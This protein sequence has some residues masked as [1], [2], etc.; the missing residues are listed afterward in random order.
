[1]TTQS[2]K[3]EYR[4]AAVARLD[5][6]LLAACEAGIEGVLLDLDGLDQLDDEGVRGLIML[7]R[8]ARQFGVE[9]SL[10]VTKAP[11]RE[12][13]RVLALDRLFPIVDCEEAA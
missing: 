10:A 13:L 7:L 2:L 5:A 12:Q 4:P 6:A 1:M 11:L 3:L 9:L 8:R